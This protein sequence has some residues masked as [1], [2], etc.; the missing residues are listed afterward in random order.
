MK[1]LYEKTLERFKLLEQNGYN[2]IYIWENDWESLNK[3]D[4]LK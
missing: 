1:E 4:K 2:V 3:Q